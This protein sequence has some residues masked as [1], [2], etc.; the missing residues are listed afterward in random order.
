MM[1]FPFPCLLHLYSAEDTIAYQMVRLIHNN[2]NKVQTINLGY[3]FLKF[4]KYLNFQVL[5]VA[6]NYKIRV[7]LSQVSRKLLL[8]SSEVY[9]SSL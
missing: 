2:L 9:D 6:L 8:N 4:Q 1:F 7:K 3:F 5:K